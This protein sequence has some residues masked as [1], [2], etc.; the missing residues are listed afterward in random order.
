MNEREKALLELP[1]KAA[2]ELLSEMAVLRS[3]QK[4]GVAA[5]IPLITLHLRNGRDMQGW[6]LK[7]GDAARGAGRQVLL[8]PQGEGRSSAWDATYIPLSSVD[9]V[10]VHDIPGLDEAPPGL[11]P[12]PGRLQLKRALAELAERLLK[13]LGKPVV[14]D[15]AWDAVPE[16]GEPL[17]GIGEVIEHVRV[18]TDD[19]LRDEMGKQS[20]KAKLGKIWFGI[21]SQPTVA[22]QGETLIVTTTA[23]PAGRM[24]RT[25][26]R[27]AIEKAL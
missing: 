22:I 21:G 26:I 8:Q 25:E 6:V 16:S 15:I 18:I 5:R 12:P 2:D 3:R 13:D 14:C 7:V 1:V 23:V 20:L 19:L 11:P 24:T 27:A 9:A 4:E 10:T 17:R